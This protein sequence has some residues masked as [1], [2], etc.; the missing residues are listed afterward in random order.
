MIVVRKHFEC[1]NRVEEYVS[2]STVFFT[3][4]FL[5]FPILIFIQIKI[6]YGLIGLVQEFSET[7]L[8]KMNGNF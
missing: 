6:F 7:L 8:E 1:S 4:F 5:N 2:I 3:F